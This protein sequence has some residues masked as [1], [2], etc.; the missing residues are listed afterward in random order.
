MKFRQL[1]IIAVFL[2]GW[3]NST[4]A[5]GYK[6]AKVYMF[7]FAA[8]FNDSTVYMTNI[9]QVDAYLM[10]DRTHFLV[11]RDDY[12][13]QLR[14]YLQNNRLESHPTCITLYAETEKAAMKKYVKLRDKYIKTK[15]RFFIKGITDS[16]FQYKTVEPAEGPVY[17]DPEQAEQ[18]ARKSKKKKERE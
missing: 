6:P 12:S 10:D 3:V 5:K 2:L 8:S 7:G 15:G 16:Q 11:S 1:I 18:A 9:Q 4:D 17:V 13:Y 14:S